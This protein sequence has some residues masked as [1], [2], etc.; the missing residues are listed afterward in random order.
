MPSLLTIFFDL[1]IDKGRDICV[2][3][4]ELCKGNPLP[5]IIPDKVII[6]AGKGSTAERTEISCN[7]NSDEAIPELFNA[8]CYAYIHF[9]KEEYNPDNDVNT[10]SVSYIGFD[11]KA[12][13]AWEPQSNIDIAVYKKL[14]DN[15]IRFV[16][17]K[18]D[19]EKDTGIEVAGWLEETCET[20]L[21]N[22]SR[23]TFLD[24]LNEWRIARKEFCYT[25]KIELSKGIGGENNRGIFPGYKTIKR[26]LN[27]YYNI[28]QAVTF[29]IEQEWLTPFADELQEVIQKLL[30]IDTTPTSDD[31]N[32]HAENDGRGYT[33]LNL[34]LY[35]PPV[36]HALLYIYDFFK[37]YLVLK[38]KTNSVWI[39]NNSIPASNSIYYAFDTLLKKK[40][41]AIF[42]QTVFYREYESVFKLI[43]IND[44]NSQG[45]FL[46]IQKMQSFEP[47]HNIHALYLLEKVQAYDDEF[48]VEETA[49]NQENRKLLLLGDSI[50]QT[51]TQLDDWLKKRP[52]NNKIVWEVITAKKED[53]SDDTLVNKAFWEK[54]LG[55]DKRLAFNL[56]F[57]LDVNAA[58]IDLPIKLQDKYS[59]Y[60]KRMS[61]ELLSDCL[62]SYDKDGVPPCAQNDLDPEQTVFMD[63]FRYLAEYN[64]SVQKRQIGYTTFKT[65]NINMHNALQAWL[66]TTQIKVNWPRVVYC[67]IS[68]PIEQRQIDD[69][70]IRGINVCR[71]EFYSM[72]PLYI[73]QLNA[74]MNSN[75]EWKTSNKKPALIENENNQSIFIDL[76]QLLK[77][78]SDIAW[79]NNDSKYQIWAQRAK[80]FSC[81]GTLN[82]KMLHL[83][84]KYCRDTVIEVQLPTMSNNGI[85]PE[86]ETINVIRFAICPKIKAELQ[87]EGI[88]VHIDLI[89][90]FIFDVLSRAFN[91]AWPEITDEKN[92]VLIKKAPYIFFYRALRDIV[93]ASFFGRA[94]TFKDLVFFDIFESKP[95]LLPRLINIISSENICDKWKIADKY[96]LDRMFQSRAIAQLSN[97]Y[98]N[99]GSQ[100]FGRQLIEAAFFKYQK[101]DEQF[102]DKEIYNKKCKY[103]K[104]A[105][106][107]LGYQNSALYHNLL[108][109]IRE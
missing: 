83:M 5:D 32:K 48:P 11:K 54:K 101:D 100:Y 37:L 76:W 73:L 29:L 87:E 4:D 20:Q 53:I 72:T 26:Y 35:S 47:R 58:Y 93:S 61:S 105:C 89:D 8:I 102:S 3:I 52:D 78:V 97:P 33:D 42:S 46:Q 44:T 34:S 82:N 106:E 10:I 23:D 57:I 2:Q 55:S 75:K 108:N 22:G 24:V 28:L 90:K 109:S 92:P 91:P 7:L 25:Q 66:N 65:S 104:A 49:V 99:Y 56:V 39:T 69:F 98:F 63:A 64:S 12:E 38:G 59:F 81:A 27:A 45:Y 16:S 6:K 95:E 18:S 50:E 60:S 1:L 40:I 84:M 51:G 80:L 31:I 15:H 88:T 70:L 79:F 62:V 13:C 71:K 94:N 21:H 36:L 85:K 96:P 17:G 67:Y 74:Q 30:W 41:R 86:N 14:C 9:K 68:P 107:M 77:P 43:D 19:Y 103:I